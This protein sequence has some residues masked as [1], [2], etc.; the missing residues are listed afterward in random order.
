MDGLWN[1]RRVVMIWCGIGLFWSSF[2]HAH[3]FLDHAEPKVGSHITTAPQTVRI[4]FTD[5]LQ[6]AKCGIQVFDSKGNQVDK[7]DTHPD[8]AD[9]TLLRISLEPLARGTFTVKWQA[10]CIDGHK[11]EGT[12]TFTLDPHP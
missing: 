9:N 10:T 6:P 11:T 7:Q 12:F 8:P 5:E 2:A 1:S 3:A 4:W